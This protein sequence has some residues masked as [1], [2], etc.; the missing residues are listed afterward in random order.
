MASL[1]TRVDPAR[2]KPPAG[3]PARRSRRVAWEVPEHGPPTGATPLALEATRPAGARMAALLAAVAATR[4]KLPADAAAAPVPLRACEEAPLPPAAAAVLVLQH[5]GRALA[6]VAR[7]GA[8]VAAGERLPARAAAGEGR[9]AAPL[10]EDAPPAVARH[11]HHPRAR[12]ARAR[13]AEQHA[14]VGAACLQVPAAHLAAGVGHLPGVKLRVA[15]LPAETEV[16]A[17]DLA[18]GVGL[19]A[20]R[21]VPRNVDSGGFVGKQPAALLGPRPGGGELLL[22]P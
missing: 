9:P 22:R 14:G 19:P 21:A 5:A 6:D 20:L 10:P 16:V 12:G 17:G 1:R 13:V 7:L 2:Q 8:A 3:L 18:R 11:V 4:Q 15:L